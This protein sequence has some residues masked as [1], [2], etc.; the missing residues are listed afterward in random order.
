MHGL[1]TQQQNQKNKPKLSL[2]S[3]LNFYNQTRGWVSYQLHPVPKS[4]RK[5]QQYQRVNKAG[6]HFDDNVIIVHMG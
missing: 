5:P 6:A 4:S 3:C 2:F 1:P